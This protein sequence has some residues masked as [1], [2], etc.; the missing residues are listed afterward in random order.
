MVKLGTDVSKSLIKPRIMSNIG[1][2]S[3]WFDMVG[4]VG[5][6]KSPFPVEIKTEFDRSEKIR[7]ETPNIP[8]FD[9]CLHCHSET[10]HF[11]TNGDSN[12]VE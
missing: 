9:K 6:R 8:L 4:N 3:L 7:L 5:G 2:S 10:R 12:L 1:L 11:S